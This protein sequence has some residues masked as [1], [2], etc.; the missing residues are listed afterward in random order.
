M[1][2][3]QST[4]EEKFIQAIKEALDNDG[5]LN[6]KKREIS[7]LL[8]SYK[9]NSR[10]LEKIIRFSDKQQETLNTKKEILEELSQKLSVYLSPQ[11]YDSIFSGKKEVMVKSERK[12]LTI[13]FSDLVN[14]TET[15]ENLEPEV[16]S[17]I[18]NNYL[19]EMLT[20]ALKHGATIDKFIGDAILIFFG[21]PESHGEKEDALR[22][23]SMAIEMRNKVNELAP[24]WMNDGLLRPFKVRM[25]MTTGYVTVGNFGGRLRMDYT[26]IGGQVNLASR[27]ESKA[28]E[29]SILI[30]HDT[31]SLVKDKIYCEK[32]DTEFVKGIP[33]P[34]PTYEVINFFKNIKQKEEISILND[35]LTL[36]IEKDDLHTGNKKDRIIETLQ[37]VIQEIKES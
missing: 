37:N 22:A 12:K 29:N 36:F 32:K 14:F 33:Y 13:F 5:D 26:V 6:E 15:T 16:L 24:K 23:V 1:E 2:E 27:L 7:K 28:N 21:D 34:V 11:I 18:L 8:R 19:D 9:K 17:S 10:Q 31:Y 3:E 25:G 4:E 35:N 20:I 30:S